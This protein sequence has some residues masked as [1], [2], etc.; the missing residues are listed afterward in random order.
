M[1]IQMQNHGDVLRHAARR[2]AVSAGLSIILTAAMLL[3]V[4]G[5]DLA[6]RVSV[7]FVIVFSLCAATSISAALSGALSYRSALLMRELSLTRCE[8]S[9]LSQTDQLTGLLNRRGFDAA[10]AA[11]L[12]AAHEAGRSA[13]AFMCDIDHFKSVNDRF[14]HDA[15]DKVLV[16]VADVLRQVV[17]EG[18][19]LVAR[20]GGEEFAALMIGMT[21]EQ[22]EHHA[23][24]IRRAC[25]ASEVMVGA[26]PL[27]VTISIGFTFARNEV[28]LARLMRTADQ[29]LYAAKRR[30]RDRVEQADERS[31]AAA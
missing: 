3:L 31:L 6:A 26:A 20:Y 19:T 17:G 2:T 5:A 1:T 28:D 22:S 4:F 30:G 12:T 8:L 29:A 7:G 11:A 25:A 27:R 24:Q 14:G 21:R 10:A 13:V 9:R 23:E 15:G 18:E 16:A